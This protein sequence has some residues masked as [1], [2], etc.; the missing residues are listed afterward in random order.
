[1]K[2]ERI[3]DCEPSYG[4]FVRGKNVAVGD[5]PERDLLDSDDENE[6]ESGPQCMDDEE[7]L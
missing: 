1:M 4:T 6:G 5:F 2:G 3:F 7:E